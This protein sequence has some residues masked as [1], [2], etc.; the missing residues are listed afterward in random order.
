[1]RD[2]VLVEAE[3][4]YDRWLGHLGSMRPKRERR[5]GCEELLPAAAD[6]TYM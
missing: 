2:F 1:M 4:M 6:N 3:F 5:Q